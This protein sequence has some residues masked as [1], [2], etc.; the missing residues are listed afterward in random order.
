MERLKQKGVDRSVAVIPGDLILSNSATC[1]LPIFV[2]FN[3]CIHDGWLHFKNLREI[4]KL[5]LYHVLLELSSHLVQIADGS[6]QKNLNTGLVSKQHVI[7][8]NENAS[9]IFES[10]VEPIFE[11][12]KSNGYERRR[13]IRL[14]DFVLFKLMAEKLDPA[15]TEKLLEFAV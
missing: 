9:K 2:E 6:V 14:R 5:Y 7:V 4:T 11:H 3:G 12:I 13:L 1:G 15:E 8:P 10:I